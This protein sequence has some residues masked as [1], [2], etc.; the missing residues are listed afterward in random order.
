M[1][2][3]EHE[4]KK[5]EKTATLGTLR[6]LKYRTFIMG[7]SVICTVNRNYSIAVT[8]YTQETWFDSGVHL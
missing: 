7:N 1:I 4:I 8:L 3:G 6:V 2:P 5:L